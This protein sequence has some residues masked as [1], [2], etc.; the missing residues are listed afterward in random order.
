M[1]QLNLSLPSGPQVLELVDGEVIFYEH[2]FDAQTSEKIYAELMQQTAWRQDAITLFGK[3]MPLPRLTAWYGDPGKSYTYSG[4][5]MDP[6]PWTPTLKWIKEAIE[7]VCEVTFNSVLLNLYRDG[8]DSVA[9]HSDDEPE[10]G[11]NPVIGSVSLGA[12]R[13]FAFKHK[14]EP[15]KYKVQSLELTSGSL[16]IMRGATQHHW[17]HQIPKTSKKVGSRINLTFRVIY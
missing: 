2:F 4:I 14:K 6:Q 10:L 7:P 13:K 9:W 3:T 17:Y 5:P 16:L 12:A 15:T 11:E 8:N 1:A